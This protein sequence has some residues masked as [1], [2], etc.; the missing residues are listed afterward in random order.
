[1][2]AICIISARGG[3]K[4]V[5]YK[6]IK[7]LGD[8]PLIAHSI[9]TAKNSKLFK[10]VIVSTDD[11]KIASIAK[12][13]GAY[14]PFMRPKKLALDSTPLE[15]VLLYTVKKLKSMKLDFD[16]FMIKDCTVP[17]IDEKDMQGAMRLFKKSN[18]NGVF[19]AIRAHPNPYFGMME[20]NSN[21]Y[22][23]ISKSLKQTITRRQNAPVVYAIDGLYILKVDIFLKT[24]KIFMSK[25]LPYEITKDHGHMID[26]PID[27]KLAECLN[28]LKK[29]LSM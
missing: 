8:K 20:I 3:S 13:Y 22:L 4:G 15:S 21:G 16:T 28:D 19:A 27:F 11:K 5:P 12:K 24:S 17:F 14:V 1:M 7:K 6:N 2:N 23:Q 18:C 26:F 25:T 10:Y 29:T 9:E